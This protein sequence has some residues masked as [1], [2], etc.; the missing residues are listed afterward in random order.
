MSNTPVASDK[1]RVIV[2]LPIELV[3]EMDEKTR[4]IGLTRSGLIALALRNLL[5]GK[6]VVKSNQEGL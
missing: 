5:D 2:T 4:E 6:L 1:K 3:D